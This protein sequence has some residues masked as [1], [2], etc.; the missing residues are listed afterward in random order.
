MPIYSKGCPTFSP[1]IWRNVA[2]FLPRKDLKTLL[3]VPHVLS[4]IASKLL[5]Q[6]LSL[7]FG[8]RR[9][10]HAKSTGSYRL[11]DVS[12]G[13]NA[14]ILARII[15]DTEFASVVKTL[16]I[17]AP[18]DQEYSMS[19]PRGERRYAKYKYRHSIDLGCCSGMLSN[20]LPKLTTLKNVH[21][22]SKWEDMVSIVRSLSDYCPRIE[23]LSLK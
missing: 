15:T 12:E 2:L 13:K 20:A 4:R 11:D 1:E 8:L 5:F 16:R 10:E 17:Y 7:H 23:G 14:E 21:C 19:F 6:D 22:R 18:D 9:R 3:S